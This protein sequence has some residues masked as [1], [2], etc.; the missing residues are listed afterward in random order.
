M[1]L[2]AQN[3]TYSRTHFFVGAESNPNQSGFISDDST[4][5][6]L[7]AYVNYCAV[8]NLMIVILIDRG[9]NCWP[10][11][12]KHTG[13]TGSMTLREVPFEHPK[14]DKRQFDAI[15]KFRFLSIIQHK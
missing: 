14:I 2:V 13:S 1:L 6:V 3:T 15:F 7:F 10:V 11:C 4:T 12:V 5:S 8:Q 9:G